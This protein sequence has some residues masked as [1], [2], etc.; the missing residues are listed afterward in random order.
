MRAFASLLLESEIFLN[1]SAC[2]A[3][4]LL[5]TKTHLLKHLSSFCLLPSAPAISGL[6]PPSSDAQSP[7]PRRLLQIWSAPEAPS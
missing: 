1:D 4:S 5:L 2:P 6:G 7:R 3:V